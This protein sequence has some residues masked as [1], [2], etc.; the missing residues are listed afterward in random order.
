MN[1]LFFI[2]AGPG[3]PKMLTLEGAEA[4]SQAQVVYLHVPYDVVFADRLNGKQLL[5]PFDYDFAELLSQIERQL[6]QGSVAFLVPGDLTFYSP[7][8]CVIDHFGEK[9]IVIAG[10][11]VANAASA[12]LKRTFDLPAVCNRALIVSPKTLGNNASDLKLEDL[13]QPGATLL[14]YMNNLPLQELVEKLRCGYASNVPIALFHRLGLSDEKVILA[15]LDTIVAACAGH[16]Y[17]YLD[18]P[19]KKPALTFVV[20][21]E[22]LNAEVDVAWWDERR[23]TDWKQCSK[24]R[25]M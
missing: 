18:D 4:L 14:L 23:K 19:T 17:F 3:D 2:G 25:K 12:K 9:S 11:G 8:Q 10:V 5:V 15:T 16:D 6:E 7:F 21:G 1:Q 24:D 20:V 22:T 13:A